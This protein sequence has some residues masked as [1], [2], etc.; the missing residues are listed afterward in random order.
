MTSRPLSGLA[1][2]SFICGTAFFVPFVAIVALVLGIVSRR[3]LGAE[4]ADRSGAG[5][6]TAGIV[7]G[8]FG[9]SLTL[10]AISV[11]LAVLPGVQREA[12]ARRE[13]EVRNN[14]KVVQEAIEEFSLLSF[15]IYPTGWND[16]AGEGKMFIELL[17]DSLANPCTGEIRPEQFIHFDLW[18]PPD[19]YQEAKIGAGEIIIYSDVYRY[20][21]IGGGADGS[22]MI[23]ALS[24][25]PY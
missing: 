8:A 11:G 23:Y 14:M 7:L 2:A 6:A 25:G 16:T 3:K 13:M 10:L 17:P 9:T 22:P 5:F 12:E 20:M 15:G 21:I 19:G 4:G 1:V 24:G 18:P